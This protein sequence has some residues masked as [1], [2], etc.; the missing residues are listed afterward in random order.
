MTKDA[1]LKK[2]LDGVRHNFK[3]GTISLTITDEHLEAWY[4]L[5]NIEVKMVRCIKDKPYRYIQKELRWFL[6]DIYYDY[7]WDGC[8]VKTWELWCLLGVDR[9]QANNII[10]KILN[11]MRLYF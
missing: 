4:F 1:M 3:Y 2:R 11:K 6:I 7:E 9:W 8:A 10:N 5:K